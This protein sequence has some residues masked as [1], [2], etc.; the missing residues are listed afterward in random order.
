MSTSKEDP[1]KYEVSVKNHYV[2]IT[3]RSITMARLL[4]AIERQ[5]ISTDYKI[6]DKIEKKYWVCRHGIYYYY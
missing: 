4:N 2:S 6:I 5:N 1:P 3:Y